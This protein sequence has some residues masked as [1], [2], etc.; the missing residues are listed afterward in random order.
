[1]ITIVNLEAHTVHKNVTL[2]KLN[3][4]HAWINCYNTKQEEI[5]EKALCADIIIVN[6][7]LITAE[8]IQALPKLKLIN[9]IATG[10]NNV[11]L[12]A[13][14]NNNVAV[15]NLQKYG[16]E[17]VAEHAI[18]MMLALSRNICLYKDRVSDLSWTKSNSFCLMNYSIQELHNKT[19]TIIGHGAIGERIGQIAKLAFNMNIIFANHKNSSVIATN[20]TD[21]NEALRLADYIS[22]NCPLTNETKNLITEKEFN[23]MKSNAIL[24]N[25]ARGG[26]V[27]EDDLYQALINNKIRGVG[28]DVTIKEPIEESNNLLKLLKTHNIIITPHCAWLGDSALNNI[29][30][31]LIEN[32]EL[33]LNGKQI[34]RVI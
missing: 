10:T 20:K 9:I 32:I 31:Q 24:I 2:P 23:L 14:K 15:T 17:S 19:L 13:C 4:P 25:V 1:M 7:L 26:I 12:I 27:N 29:G 16:T 3:F 33:F 6:K 8:I 21:F 28:I 22:I 34:R 30:N 11:D 5:I 18:S